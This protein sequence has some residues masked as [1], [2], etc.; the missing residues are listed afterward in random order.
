[1]PPSGNLLFHVLF[2]NPLVSH[3]DVFNK[4]FLEI[5]LATE[6]QCSKKGIHDTDWSP[7]F[8]RAGCMVSY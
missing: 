1:M 5:R 6:K 3:G 7:E 8:K 4:Q 2:F